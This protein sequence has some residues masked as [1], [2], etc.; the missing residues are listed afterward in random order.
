MRGV[1][2]KINITTERNGLR[3]QLETLLGHIKRRHEGNAAL[4]AS[5]VSPCFGSKAPC[6]SKYLTP[7]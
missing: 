3:L 1:Q 7:D 6:L 2:D 4:N 5:Q